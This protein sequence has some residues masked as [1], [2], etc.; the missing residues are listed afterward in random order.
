MTKF[1]V[2]VV[3]QVREF[4]T[5]ESEDYDSAYEEAGYV[6]MMSNPQY[7][8]GTLQVLSCDKEEDL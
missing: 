4:L 6:V 5:Y 3:Y 2:E 7:I 8:S 1:N